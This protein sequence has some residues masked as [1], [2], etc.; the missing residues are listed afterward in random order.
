MYT[1]AAGLGVA[2]DKPEVSKELKP[3]QGKWKVVKAIA[4]EQDIQ[5]MAR[6]VPEQLYEVSETRPML[7]QAAELMRLE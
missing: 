5:N 1:A 7:F 2:D 4:K 3:F 6:I